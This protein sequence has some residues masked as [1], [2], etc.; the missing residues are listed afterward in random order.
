[1]N[2]G[3]QLILSY[4]PNLTEKQIEQLDRLQE[5]YEDWNSKINDV[6]R[7]RYSTGAELC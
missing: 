1:M 5:L 4:F 2:T 7:M 3:T 6:Q